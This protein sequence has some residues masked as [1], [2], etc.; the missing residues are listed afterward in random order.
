MVTSALSGQL[1]HSSV[2][3]EGGNVSEKAPFHLGPKLE[4]KR[5]PKNEVKKG[6]PLHAPLER[7]L[8]PSV[9]ILVKMLLEKGFETRSK[10]GPKEDSK[11]EPSKNLI[12]IH[13]LQRFGH[14]GGPKKIELVSGSISSEKS[15]S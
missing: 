5:G 7:F 3:E 14:V 2:G 10:R 8:S 6:H 11:E 15:R 13:Y 4:S 1:C 9:G 12:S